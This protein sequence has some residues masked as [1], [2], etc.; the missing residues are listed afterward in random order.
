[1]ASTLYLT[2]FTRSDLRGGQALFTMMTL[3]REWER[4]HGYV[5]ALVPPR[6]LFL[7][8]KSGKL[9][10][11]TYRRAF[12]DSRDVTKL[13]PGALQWYSPANGLDPAAWGLV[14]DGDTVCCGCGVAKAAEG[15]CHRKWLAPLLVAAGWD[16]V[17]DGVRQV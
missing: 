7:D 1:M 10:L 13:P 14:Q 12:L 11:D 5:L 9:D 2:T 15:R 3:P 8:R 17:L 16:V 4:G 6:D